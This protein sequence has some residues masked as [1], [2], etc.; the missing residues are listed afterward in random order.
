MR[1]RRRQ[2]KRSRIMAAIGAVALLAAACGA[3]GGE[4][5]VSGEEVA[6]TDPADTAEPEPATP[7]EG[8]DEPEEPAE[9]DAEEATGDPIDIGFLAPTTGSVAASGEDMVRGWD[10]YW[11]VNGN[12]VAGREIITH[13]EDTAGDPAVGLNMARRLVQDED[14]D[15]IAG[16]LLANVGLAV[17]EYLS[18]AGVPLFLPVASADDLTQREPLDGVLRVGGWTSS[19]TTHPYGE[20]AYEQGYRRMVT[21][22]TDYAFGHE[23]CGGFANTFTD[24]GGEIVEQIWYP[25]GTQDFGTYIA[26]IQ[27]A[28]ADA[29]FVVGVGADSPRF[30]EAWSNFGMTDTL[31]LLGNETLTDQSVLRGMG[32]EAE[33]IISTGKF[34]E[35]RDAP[36][37]QAFVEAFDEAYDLLPSYY[38]STSYIAAQWT[39]NALEEVGGDIEDT[40][41]F[42]EA[43][44]NL[45]FESPGGPQALDEYDNPIQNVYI[46]EVQARDDGRLWNVPIQ[47]FEDVSQFWTYDVDEFLECPVYSRDYQGLGEFPENC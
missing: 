2:G 42:L 17:A 12:Q 13:H 15:L 23:N 45:E 11:E 21:I 34:A 24:A 38:A 31:P 37:T 14:V 41:T 10:L 4:E 40:E 16:P 44:R 28:D 22:C 47:T 32:P 43:V 20:Y 3:P 27:A 35:G 33:G 26:Q 8:E 29:V 36:E 30:V 25:L 7:E 5:E 46:R 1:G 19:Q 9:T 18:G 6:P 39:A